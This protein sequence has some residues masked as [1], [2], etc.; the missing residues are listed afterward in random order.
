MTLIIPSARAASVPGRIWSQSVARDDSA[1]SLGSITMRF[2]TWRSEF[3]YQTAISPSALD[4]SSCLAQ[5]ICVLG[6]SP[7]QP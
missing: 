1:V 2:F 6:Y 3:M 5:E 4:I 7:P